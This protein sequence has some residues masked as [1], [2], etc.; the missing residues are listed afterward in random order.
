VVLRGLQLVVKKYPQI[1]ND[2]KMFFIRYNDPSYVKHEK[3]N[4][5][6]ALANDKNYEIVLNEFNEYAYDM[7]PEFTRVTVRCIWKLA[8]RISVSLSRYCLID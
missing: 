5:I 6:F 8:L 3:L 4:L 7:D 1:F 2:V